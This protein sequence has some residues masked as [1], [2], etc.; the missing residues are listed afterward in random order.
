MIL[1]AGGKMGPSLARMARRAADEAGPNRRVVAVSRF[2]SSGAVAAL[3]ACGVGVVRADLADRNALSALPDAPNVILLAGQKFGTRDDPA[4]TWMTNVVLPA[5]VADRFST[6]RIVALSTGNVY[7][8]VPVRGAGASES[9]AVTPV[10]EYAWTC[11]GRERVLGHASRQ[12]GTR[13]A[14][15]RLNYAVDLRYGVLVDVALKV[16]RGEP[17]DVRMGHANVIW[18]GDACAQVLQ[19]LPHGAT[20]PFV[21][22][23]T[24]AE[25]LAI[26]AVALELGRILG[27]EP[28]IVGREADDALLSNTARAQ[29]LFGR[30]AVSSETLL[31]WVAEWV[32]NGNPLLG[33]ATHFEEREGRF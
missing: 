4:A 30:P 24:G 7:P 29:S 31:A 12:R 19:C 2:G 6:A 25:R 23:V 14:I 27:R 9:D 26:R 1:G 8:L 10:G 32:R 20:P 33:K 18:Q 15:V 13:V 22:N 5:A 17:V 11:V 16:W 3:E 28:R 21:V